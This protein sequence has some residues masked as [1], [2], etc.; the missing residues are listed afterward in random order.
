[1]LE[2]CK[3]SFGSPQ[4]L[5]ETS[6]TGTNQVNHYMWKGNKVKMEYVYSYPKASGSSNVAESL[7]LVYTYNDFDKKVE[8]S[9][10]GKYSSKDF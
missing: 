1:L 3:A 10:K 7:Q 8:N 4:D 9:N 2:A 5:S 6:R